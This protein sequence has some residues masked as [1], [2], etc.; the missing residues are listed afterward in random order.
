M[1]NGG[2]AILDGWPAQTRKNPMTLKTLVAI[3]LLLGLTVPSGAMT[4]EEIKRL[5]AA[6]VEKKLPDEHPASYYVY[7]G[8]LFGEG[9]KDEAVF[10]FYAG[11]LRY[12]FHLKANPNLPPSGDPAL[13]AS[14]SE[15]V[16][17]PIN[18]YAFG[19]IRE[20]TKQ[21]D[22]ALKWDE[23]TPNGFTSKQKFKGIYD[24]NR[25]GL[26]SMRSQVESQASS[27]REQR[28]KAGLENRN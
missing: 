11:Q 25:N 17:R 9:K 21:I 24:D 26:K 18:E 28:T 22:R 10:W 4:P 19:S 7:A 14:L 1:I 12:R 23:D 16:G 8:R 13:F 27:I 5:P 3:V 6:E 15:T 2:R 20:L